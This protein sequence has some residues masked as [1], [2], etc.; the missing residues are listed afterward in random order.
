[1]SGGSA[2]SDDADLIDQLREALGTPPRDDPSGQPESTAGE[3]S[4]NVQSKASV[5]DL[6]TQTSPAVSRAAL[7]IADS[8]LGIT[9]SGKGT[10]ENES[11]GAVVM[12]DDICLVVAGEKVLVPPEGVVLGRQP[13]PTGVVLA[14]SH[15]SR[16]HMSLIPTPAGVSVSDLRSTNGTIILRGHDQIEVGRAATPIEVGDT[17]ITTDGVQIAEVVSVGYGLRGHVE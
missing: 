13:G 11:S 10:L 1:M 3:E 7:D 4:P 12:E 14:N 5:G 6:P 8:I 17:I 15:I 9:D 16:R 2:L